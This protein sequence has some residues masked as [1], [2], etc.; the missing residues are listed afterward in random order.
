MLSHPLRRR[1]HPTASPSCAPFDN[2]HNTCRPFF[3]YH[4]RRSVIV[5]LL[6]ERLHYGAQ[7]MPL[8]R[9][10]VLDLSWCGRCSVDTHLRSLQRVS[11]SSSSS[12]CSSSSTSFAQLS[13]P[14]SCRK[15]QMCSAEKCTAAARRVTGS[16]RS[17]SWLS[18]LSA[19]Y[20]GAA[21]VNW[22]HNV[23]DAFS[24]TNIRKLGVP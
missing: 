9:L 7:Y 8:G 16:T 5:G 15:A 4:Q 22:G 2:L 23:S 21:G 6:A 11:S 18:A 24:S 14:A 17:T 12:C 1:L 13:P 19:P 3:P 10:S 20:S